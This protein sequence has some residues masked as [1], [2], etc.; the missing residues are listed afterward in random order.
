MGGCLQARGD[1]LEL[2]GGFAGS[3]VAKL[4]GR[5]G[6]TI[7]SRENFFRRDIVELSALGQPRRLH[8]G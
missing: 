8:G 1:T 2:G 3:Y 7:V 6:A 4:L 5:D